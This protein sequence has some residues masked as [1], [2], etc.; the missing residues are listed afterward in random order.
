MRAVGI[1]EFGG[2]EKL[3]V[4]DLPKPSPKE[5]EI[6]VKVKAAGVNPVDW[7]IR[8]GYLQKMIPHAFPLVLGWDVAGVVEELGAGV[9]RFKVGD[10]VMAYCRKDVV[11]W[12]AYAEWVAFPESCAAKKPQI[13]SFAEAA[14]VPVAALTAWQALFDAAKLLEG[15]TVLVHAAAGGVGSYGVELAAWRKAEVVATAAARNHEWVRNLGAR[16]VIDYQVVDFRKAVKELYPGG[17]DVVL[18]GVGGETLRRSADVLKKGGR[19]A[20]IVDA[21]DPKDAG[22]PDVTFQ[23]VFVAPNAKQLE[24]IGQLMELKRLTPHL[25]AELPLD[26]AAKAHK[27]SAGGH[28]RGKIALLT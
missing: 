4:L 22:R 6:L 24:E 20:G 17:V 25:T 11:Q 18:D 23:H 8:E 1:T 21:F 19:I 14:T 10:A 27:L 2:I 5:K 16:H 7:K 3:Q 15:E 13:L 9:T 26:Q 28:F 12:G